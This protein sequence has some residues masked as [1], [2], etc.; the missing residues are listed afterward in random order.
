MGK[1]HCWC[2]CF[3]GFDPNTCFYIIG[4]T[5][6]IFSLILGIIDLVYYVYYLSGAISGSNASAYFLYFAMTVYVGNSIKSCC[7]CC[8]E[9]EGNPGKDLDT[10][11]GLAF[12]VILFALI[13]GVLKINIS[14]PTSMIFFAYVI[15]T[16]QSKDEVT[17]LRTRSNQAE[18]GI[19]TFFLPIGMKHHGFQC[20]FKLR[21][22]KWVLLN[23]SMIMML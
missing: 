12:L 22:W 8:T 10:Y 23:D 6:S 18:D 1:W 14:V 13:D 5:M 15:L 19:R 20:L 17:G 2:D 9:F 3:F 11:N 4:F 21:G 7:L 16:C